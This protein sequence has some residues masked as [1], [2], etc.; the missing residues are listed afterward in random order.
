MKLLTKKGRGMKRKI[1]KID[2]DKCTGCGECVPNCAEGALKIVNGKAKLVGEA[3]CDGLGA[4]LGECPTGALTIEE[5]EAEDF[6]EEKVKEHLETEKSE[7]QQGCPG[8]KVMDF[9][10]KK[11]FVSRE[12]GNRPSALSQWPVQL[13]LLNPNAPYFKEADLVIAADCVPFSYPNFHSRFLEGKILIVFC[14]KLDNAFNEYIDKLAEILKINNIKS[15][16]VAR[17]E[18]PCCGGTTN[19]VQEALKKSGKNIILKEYTIS[20]KGEII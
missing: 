4:C 6:N 5:R 13:K 18:V 20:I 2:E 19:I 14:P 11:P 9:R 15:I 10:D 7:P 16:T 17:M 1:I 12:A 3:L 8:M